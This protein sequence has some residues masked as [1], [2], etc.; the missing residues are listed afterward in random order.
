MNALLLIP[1]ILSSFLHNPRHSSSSVLKPMPPP[2]FFSVTQVYT[3]EVSDSWFNC[4]LQEQ[5]CGNPPDPTACNDCRYLK[6]TN[7]SVGCYFGSAGFASESCFSLCDPFL[8][9]F[10]PANTWQP[11]STGGHQPDPDIIYECDHKQR[12][13]TD[14][15]S[16]FPA[17]WVLIGPG[18]YIY[19]KI[20]GTFPL[21]ID[22]TISNCGTPP[23][24]CTQTI[25]LN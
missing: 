8:G 4:P 3:P 25:T 10:H 11:T 15:K 2:C 9:S 19:V 13:I 24:P 22:I 6:I 21:T 18:E 1:F 7:N 20:C 12:V 17:N 5:K 23:T 14:T 16:A